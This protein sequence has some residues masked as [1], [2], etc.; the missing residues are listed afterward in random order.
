LVLDLK[1]WCNGTQEI[2]PAK[3]NWKFNELGE[4][5]SKVFGLS[6]AWRFRVYDDKM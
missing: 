6:Q 4:A 1:I 2:I 3:K 5:C